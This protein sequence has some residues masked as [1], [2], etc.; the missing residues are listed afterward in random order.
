[1]DVVVVTDDE[2]RKNDENVVY[3]EGFK[4]RV[5]SFFFDKEKL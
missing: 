1:M 3:R 4:M 2:E 5:V